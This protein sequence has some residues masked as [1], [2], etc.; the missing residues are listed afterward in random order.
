[1]PIEEL[2]LILKNVPNFYFALT[3]AGLYLPKESSKS[4]TFKYLLACLN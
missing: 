3:N 4:V 2:N 1:M